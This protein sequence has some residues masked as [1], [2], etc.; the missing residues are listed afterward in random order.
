MSTDRT[1]LLII[2][3]WIEEGSSMPLRADIR[4][5]TDISRGLESERTVADAEIVAAI[6]QAW[7]AQFLAGSGAGV[8]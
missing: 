6:V 2:R 4:S 7:L 3:A 1:G 5:T 8:T